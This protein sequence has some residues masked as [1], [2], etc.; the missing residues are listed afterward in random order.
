MKNYQIIYEKYNSE[1]KLKLNYFVIYHGV[2]AQNVP[3]L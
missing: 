2:P 1:L 3:R